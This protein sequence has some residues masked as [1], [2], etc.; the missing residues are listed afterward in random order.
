MKKAERQKRTS[1]PKTH[2]NANL[3][4]MARM[5]Y[6]YGQWD[7]KYWFIGPEQG[8]GTE[9]LLTR[10][11]AWVD[12]GR[13]DLNDCREFHR[14]IGETRWHCKKLRPKLQSTWRRLMLLMMT[15]LEMPA[16]RESLRNYQRDQW[17]RS[18]GETCVIELS[19]LAAPSLKE[20]EDTSLF[21][22]ERIEVIR[23]KIADHKPKLVVMYGD[24]QRASWEAIAS[25]L[26]FTDENFLL[27]GSTIFACTPHPNKRGLRDA[28]FTDMGR[29]LRGL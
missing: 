29:R 27:N 6:G 25:P 10:V 3:Y 5:S 20:A 24:M 11:R 22:S 13:R 9:D 4:E 2:M 14:R 1:E 18:G 28:Y 23:G 21:L 16:D 7:A 15:F 19:G 26:S 12:L 17:G 8:I